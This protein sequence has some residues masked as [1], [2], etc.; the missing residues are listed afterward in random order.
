MVPYSKRGVRILDASY[1][2][3]TRQM[4]YEDIRTLVI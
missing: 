2:A 3:T 1:S 4:L